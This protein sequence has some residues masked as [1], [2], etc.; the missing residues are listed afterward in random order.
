MLTIRTSC[1]HGSAHS[2]GVSSPDRSRS[3]ISKISSWCHRRA[4]RAGRASCSN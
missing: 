4:R 2:C 1:W 3:C